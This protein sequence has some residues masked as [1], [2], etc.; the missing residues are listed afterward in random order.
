MASESETEA[1]ASPLHVLV[2]LRVGDEPITE[3]LEALDAALT[4]DLSELA[5]TLRVPSEH[6][7]RAVLERICEAD[8]RIEIADPPAATSAPAALLVSVPVRAHLGVR[9]LERIRER[10]LSAEGR[11]ELVLT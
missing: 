11:L 10:A 3:V 1:T 9:S 2:E 4:N 6:P 7:G 5:V 8:H